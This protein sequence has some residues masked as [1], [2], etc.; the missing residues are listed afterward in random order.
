[1]I[2]TC[3]LVHLWIKAVVLDGDHSQ[4]NRLV[5]ETG[6][7]ALIDFCEEEEAALF[8]VN[9]KEVE[10]VIDSEL[11][12]S[13]A[14]QPQI[15]GRIPVGEEIQ[16]DV[17]VRKVPRE[18]GAMASHGRVSQMNLAHLPRECADWGV[19]KQPSG[20][21]DDYTAAEA[22]RFFARQLRHQIPDGPLVV[23]MDNLTSHRQ[24][25]LV[26]ELMRMGIF[27]LYL[28]PNSLSFYTVYTQIPYAIVL[29]LFTALV[30]GSLI[31]ILYMHMQDPPVDAT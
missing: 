8:A 10:E 30:F 23:V 6:A 4:P 20:A 19:I 12:A 16:W 13:H 17:A 1:M 31:F 29:A 28:P 15:N 5:V 3:C 7:T 21:T 25:G 24:I 9:A 11:K 26:E 27:P 2:L 14:A 22:M 18:I